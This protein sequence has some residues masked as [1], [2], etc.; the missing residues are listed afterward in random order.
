MDIQNLSP[1]GFAAN[2]YLLTEGQ[3]AVLID[4]TVP[5]ATLKAALDLAGATLR[6][7]LLTHG[8]FDHLLTLDEVKRATGVPIYLGEGDADLPGDGMKNAC[9]VFMGTEKAYPAADVLFADHAELTFGELCV[10]TML[11]PGHTRG[12]SLFLCED[13]AF[14]GDTIFKAGYGRYDLYGGDA[15][16][17]AASLGKIGALPASTTIYPGHGD[18]ARL[19][20]ALDHLF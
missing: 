6:A 20:T 10:V 17:L 14:T 9:T 16:T 13:V 5:M 7:V 15:K 8:H 2:C 1:G 4:C 12:S 19:G 11:T 18:K 3:D